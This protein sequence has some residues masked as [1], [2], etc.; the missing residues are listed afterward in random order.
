MA[1][2]KIETK[3][4]SE[5]NNIKEELTD[6]INIQIKKN[7]TEEVEKANKR[8][9]REKNKKIFT[10]NLI[11]IILL[12]IIA[13]LLYLLYDNHYFDKYFNS[14]K[15][16]EVINS[17]NNTINNTTEEEQKVVK[18]LDELKKEY[19]YLLDNILINEKSKYITDYYNGNLTNELKNYLT[20]NKINIAE[21]SIE[22]ECNII[23]ESEFIKKYNELF[24]SEY[25]SI[26]FDYNGT[27][28]K[29][30]KKLE[31]YISDTILTESKTNIKREIINIETKDDEVMITTIEGIVKKD[32][33]YNVTTSK[34]V[35][36]Y[37]QDSLK[38]YESKLNKVTYT[39]KDNK[40][41][42]IK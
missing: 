37:K 33:L 34:E 41:I 12:F 24:T 21:L 2:K 6:Y 36:S 38:N 4:I 30:I 25:Q 17:T 29:Y 16:E 31:S 15:V 19:G 22:E 28:L 18:T 7:F 26:S 13:F 40:L 5:I 23:D 32:K 42:N 39:F 27:K 8:L 11:I 14:C 3:E 1:I 35:T 10:R 20:L 9:I